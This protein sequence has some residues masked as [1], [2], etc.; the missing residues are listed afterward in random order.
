MWNVTEEKTSHGTYSL[1]SAFS[2]IPIICL[3]YTSAG[4]I[5]D[6]YT[7]RMDTVRASILLTRLRGFRGF[8]SKL[9]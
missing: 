6:R 1:W 8:K 3:M 9:T 2:N 5:L 4:G 7:V